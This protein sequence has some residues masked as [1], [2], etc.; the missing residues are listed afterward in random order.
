MVGRCG[1][2]QSK[3]VLK[4]PETERL[5]LQYDEPLSNF[6]FEFNVRRYTTGIA[7]WGARRVCSPARV[8]SWRSSAQ[9][10]T[11]R[12]VQ[13]EGLGFRVYLDPRLKSG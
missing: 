4:A 11:G 8:C 9:G 7:C 10:C 1:L 13:V 5:R 2:T 3:P 12:A 6:A